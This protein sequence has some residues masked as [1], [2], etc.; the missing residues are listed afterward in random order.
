MRSIGIG[1]ACIVTLL[2]ASA[3]A[4]SYTDSFSYPNGTNVP[5]WTEHRGNWYVQAGQLYVTSLTVYPV[6][7]FITKDGY[8]LTD[9]VTEVTV[10]YTGPGPTIQSGG[11]LARA[12]KPALAQNVVFANVQ[13]NSTQTQ[14][15]GHDSF[16]VYELG[17]AI[18]RNAQ[19]L[20][21]NPTTSRLRLV[22]VD[23][24]AMLRVDLDMDGIWDLSPTLTLVSELGAGGTGC[25]AGHLPR[26]PPSSKLDDFALFDAVLT[27][28]G[29][30]S[31]GSTLTLNLRGRRATSGYQ[32]ACS[33]SN[34]GIP[35]GAR[36]V[37][38]AYDAMMVLSLTAP[39]MFQS[40]TG[41]LDATASA[42]SR[43]VIPN[44]SALSG[45]RFYA[46]FVELWASAPQG[47]HS[48]SNDLPIV[49]Q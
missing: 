5:G 8:S 3:G 40:F 24:L 7:G 16:F 29:V 15:D 48:I 36:R 34:T 20:P 47:V 18:G 39:A 14:P 17:P 2:A 38:L 35:L 22:V 44:S 25:M 43:I 42:T 1:I 46:G 21:S 49:I 10:H 37:P 11:L 27:A 13:D 12:T 26:T 41:T 30:A 23:N 9:S 45:L 6:Y 33:L 19:T 31:P 32:V 28:T 4:Q